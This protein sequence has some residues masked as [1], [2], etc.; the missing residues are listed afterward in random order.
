MTCPK[1]GAHEGDKDVLVCR[2][3]GEMLVDDDAVNEVAPETAVDEEI[4][5]VNEEEVSEEISADETDADAENAAAPADPKP[6]KVKYK[7]DIVS[8]I[9][10]FLA[11][12][13]CTLLVVGCVNGTFSSLYQKI[14]YGNPK[15]V[16]TEYCEAFLAKDGEGILTTLSDAAADAYIEQ[17][18]QYGAYYGLET[19]ADIDDS[20]YLTMWLEYGYSGVFFKYDSIEDYKCEYIKRGTNEFESLLA[21]YEGDVDEVKMAATVSFKLNY[22]AAEA[23][24]DTMETPDDAAFELTSTTVSSA[25]A[26][27]IGNSWYLTKSLFS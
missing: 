17:I 27:K 6:E 7:L 24:S 20:E 9:T 11:G 10:S 14:I 25:T 5:V 8:V 19:S 18:E 12:V 1:C 3:C 15:K 23:V 4:P 13:L 26:I 2:M 22:S 16:V 21:E